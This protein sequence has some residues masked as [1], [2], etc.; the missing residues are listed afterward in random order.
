VGVAVNVTGVAAQTGLAEARM[1]TLT[2]RFG[3]TVIV[4]VFDVAGFP[5]AHVASEVRIT[6][7]WSLLTGV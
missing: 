3:F 1:E 7:T 4:T 6:V 5:V 2:G